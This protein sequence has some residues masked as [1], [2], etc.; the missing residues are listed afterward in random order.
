M[1]VSTDRSENKSADGR[2]GG[3]R[4]LAEI[5]GGGQGKIVKAVC[6][7]PPFDG[8]EPG[9]VVALKVMSVFHDEGG[10]RWTRLQERTNALSKLS[11]PGVVKY[12]GCFR[13]KS[14]ISE[15]HVIVMECLEGENLRQRLARFPRG[16]DADEALRITEA[17]IAGL[18]YAAANG[19]VHRD[20]KPS[21]IFLCADGG[22]K[23]IDFELAFL[24]EGSTESP[25]STAT[26]KLAGTYDYM[27]PEFVVEVGFG[28]DE[29][30]DVFSMGVV[31]HEAITGRTPY[32]RADAVTRTKDVDRQ[33]IFFSFFA[34]WAC[35]KTDG[36]NPIKIS[37]RANR[38]LAHSDEV[39]AK[40]LAPLPQDRYQT[41]VEFHEGL[42][43]IH[44]RELR[45]GDRV[46]R[47]LQIIG[48]GGFCE[49][50][51]AR[52]QVSGQLVA[53]KH[54][55]KQEYGD[56]LRREARIIARFDDPH[57]PRFVD[58]FT[59]ERNGIDNAF[60]VMEYLSEMPGSTLRDAIKSANGPNLPWREIFTAFAHYAHALAM[61]H[62]QGIVHRD[63]KPSNLYYLKGK[64]EKATIMDFGIARDVN[65]TQ[66]TGL[67]PGTFDYMP[68]EIFLTDNRG[69]QGMDIYALGLSLYEALTGT[70][71]YPRLPQG[72]AALTALVTRV[73]IKVQPSFDSPIVTLYPRILALLK[74]MTNIDSAH[75]IKDAAEVGRRIGEIIQ[76][77]DLSRV[78][79]V[80]IPPHYLLDD[81][82]NTSV[83]PDCPV[84]D[85]DEFKAEYEAL[86]KKRRQKRV[87][88]LLAGLLMAIACCVLF[89]YGRS[90]SLGYRIVVDVLAIAWLYMLC[91][92]ELKTKRLPNV[93]TL[94][95]LALW[96][97]L[98]F[99]SGG[100]VGLLAGGKAAGVGLL[101]MLAPFLLRCLGGGAV[102]MAIACCAY[103]GW[104][105]LMPLGILC[106][107]LG[108]MMGCGVCID[109]YWNRATNKAEARFPVSPI[110]ACAT[111]TVAILKWIGWIA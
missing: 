22:V 37:T 80:Q 109:R 25:D 92:I 33:H 73:K 9:T 110:L 26:R 53:I 82:W 23:L 29:R 58:F 94:G 108:V 88:S 103:V 93:L 48:K 16:L 90:N 42:K 79:D 97:A 20:V 87:A 6:E 28:G 49:V 102:K 83:C 70:T 78:D 77:E 27:A 45:N 15:N 100:V 74:D 24:A 19:I 67:V 84:F 63:I 7:A 34:R 57:L 105:R 75:R 30:S 4:I 91:T 95:G 2:I 86:R 11:H 44:F 62:E 21:N 47:I 56:R 13:E 55:L 41:F 68:P 65:G 54:L 51:K 8:I 99:A 111:L 71:A 66:T 61:L 98:G 107:V 32:P 76:E 69:D 12:Y 39:L 60:F 89:W 14:A 10:R 40:V 81:E 35:L 5:H 17:A 52:Q 18:E 104:G 31:M 1:D 36:T 3:F 101:L 96:L 50:F 72:A 59:V 106:V 43:L 64:P 38:L 46:Y 85:E